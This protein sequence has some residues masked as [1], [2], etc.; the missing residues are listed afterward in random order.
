M[1]LCTNLKGKYGSED[2]TMW[3]SNIVSKKPF[4]AHYTTL[5]DE[6]KD[7]SGYELKLLKKY[8]PNNINFVRKNDNVKL[9]KNQKKSTCKI[10]KETKLSYSILHGYGTNS[11]PITNM[12]IGT[13]V[14]IAE[15]EEIKPWELLKKLLK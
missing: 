15:C 7:Y 14:K 5:K 8:A 9:Y 4:I 13:L 1:K 3:I 11:K 6:A 10:S 12:T 2:K